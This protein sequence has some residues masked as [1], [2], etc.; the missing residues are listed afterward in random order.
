M[1]LF[2]FTNKSIND[3][4]PFDV[5]EDI[6]FHMLDDDAFYRKH[7]MPC[8]DKVNSCSN[9]DQIR[10]YIEPMMN[11]CV[12]HYINKYDI[13]KSPKELLKPEDK[14]TLYD[15]IREYEKNPPQET[16]DEITKSI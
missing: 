6:H 13:P 11:K 8:M 7:Y 10:S 12:N 9:E 3:D 15:R 2:E 14:A 5:I 16:K 4:L 1:K